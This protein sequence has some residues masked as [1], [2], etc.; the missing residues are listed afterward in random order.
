[1]YSKSLNGMCALHQSYAMNVYMYIAQY[2][3]DDPCDINGL[4]IRLHEARIEGAYR[5]VSVHRAHLLRHSVFISKH[6]IAHTFSMPECKWFVVVQCICCWF[7]VAVAMYSYVICQLWAD[8]VAFLSCLLSS[9]DKWIDYKIHSPF[10]EEMWHRC[11]LRI[12]VIIYVYEL[13]H[14]GG[15]FG[16]CHGFFPKHKKKKKYYAFLGCRSINGARNQTCCD[17][18]KYS[19]ECHN[20][21]VYVCA[22]KYHCQVDR[23]HLGEPLCAEYDLNK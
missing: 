11:H 9:I 12:I 13:Q 15:S 8:S 2:G 6:V 10:S 3:D 20:C 23:I 18:D 16:R 4:C 14:A 7:L 22:V 5:I 17:T 1:M 21:P 19:S